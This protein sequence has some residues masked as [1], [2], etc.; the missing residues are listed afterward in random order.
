MSQ[1]TYAAFLQ[2]QGLDATEAANLAAHLAAIDPADNLIPTEVVGQNEGAFNPVPDILTS[3][4][5]EPMVLILNSTGVNNAG[6]TVDT[7]LFSE[8]HIQI[9]CL[10]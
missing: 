5:D 1:D 8:A 10:R 4:G 7:T 9:L 6:N 2:S 3:D